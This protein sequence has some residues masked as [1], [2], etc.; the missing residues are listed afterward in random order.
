MENR[1]G[2]IVIGFFLLVA[3]YGI[4]NSFLVAKKEKIYTV[5][6]VYESSEPGQ[7]GKTYFLD[8]LSTIKNMKAAQAA[9]THFQPIK[10][11]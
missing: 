8:I 1:I 6:Q 9:Y 3:I 2:K 10:M 4:I 7:R 5:G 11:D